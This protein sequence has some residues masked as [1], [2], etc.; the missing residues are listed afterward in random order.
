[1]ISLY[2]EELV[3]CP[4]IAEFPFLDDPKKSPSPNTDSTQHL[5]ARLTQHVW[6]HIV[7][8]IVGVVTGHERNN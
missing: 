2:I 7:V 3:S 6:G 4:R 1:M 8:N 5:V